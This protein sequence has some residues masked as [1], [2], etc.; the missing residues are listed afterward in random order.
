MAFLPKSQ[1]RNARVVAALFTTAN[2]VLSIIV[3]VSFDRNNEALQFVQRMTWIDA[4]Q[5]GF[6]VQYAVG[7]D[8]LSVT[9]MLLT[10][11]LFVVASLVSWNVTLRTREY[12]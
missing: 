12:Y 2:L 8:G 3:F 4:S 5:A 10:G 11:L 6:D 9:M 1:E 7:V